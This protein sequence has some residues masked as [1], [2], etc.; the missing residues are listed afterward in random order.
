WGVSG[1]ASAQT[2][3]PLTIT[4][5]DNSNTGG[6]NLADLVAGVDPN[7][8]DRTINNWIPRSAFTDAKQF[9]YGNSGRGIVDSPGLVLFDFSVL[10]EFRFRESKKIEFRADFF[11][12]FNHANFGFPVTTLTSGA[13]GTISSAA[14]PRDIQLGLKIVF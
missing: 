6:R 4:T 13:F 9:T 3:F 10:R 7:P 1:I 14:E 12:V 5:R 2:G 11:N 8:S